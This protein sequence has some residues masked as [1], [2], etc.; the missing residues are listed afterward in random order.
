MGIVLNET[1]ANQTEN[2]SSGSL[3]VSAYKEI[4]IDVLPSEVSTQYGVTLS[5]SR[6]DAN[7]NLFNLN[8][9]SFQ[10]ANPI[11]MSIGPGLITNASLGENIQ[12][13]LTI[14]SGDSFSGTISVIGK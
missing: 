3:D 6:F 2:Y 8:N 5:V 11:S 7:G 4:A 9:V 1:L 14:F 13:D 10:Y 12:I